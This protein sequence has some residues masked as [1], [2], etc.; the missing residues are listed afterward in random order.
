[1]V[2]LRCPAFPA[3]E[4]KPAMKELAKSGGFVKLQRGNTSSNPYFNIN[5]MPQVVKLPS[6]SCS[7][8]RKKDRPQTPL[9]SRVR[10]YS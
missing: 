2:K 5:M 3:V 4:T 7:W 8:K 6:L 1:M 10:G 9:S